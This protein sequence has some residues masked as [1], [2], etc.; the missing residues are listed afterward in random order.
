MS[1]DEIEKKNQ[2]HKT[3]QKKKIAIEKIKDQI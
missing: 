2:S 3:I 1:N